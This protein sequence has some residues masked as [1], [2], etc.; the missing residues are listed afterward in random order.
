MSWFPFRQFTVHQERCAHRVGTDGMLLGAWTALPPSG[1]VLD[2]GTGTGVLALMLAQ[3]GPALAFDALEIDPASAA[4][5]AENVA[6]SPWPE[7][8]AVH[9]GALQDWQTH[10]RYAL[11]ICNPPFF[12]EPKRAQSPARDRA[13]HS[14]S[15]P[16]GELLAHS[17]RLLQPTGQLSV[18]LPL[19]PGERLIAE[20][21]AQGWQLRRRWEVRHS[22]E[23]A[24]KRLLLGLAAPAAERPPAEACETGTLCLRERDGS[25]TAAYRALTADYHSLTAPPGQHPRRDRPAHVG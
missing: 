4:Q 9:T 10:R 13:R 2:V 24:P 6:G 17:Q 12:D 5:A 23:H 25:F 20:A 11:V 18:I 7:R 19:Q 1:W 22:S 21:L 16:H 3:R 14:A 15:L 8:I